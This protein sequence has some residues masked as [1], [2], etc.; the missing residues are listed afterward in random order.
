MMLKKLKRMVTLIIIIGV[1]LLLV[2]NYGTFK[3][4]IVGKIFKKKGAEIQREIPFAP[5]AEIIPV[6]VFKAKITAFKDTLP[7]LGNIK[8]FRE[9]TLKFEE[10]GVVE[11]FNFEEGERVE[12]GD[13][14]A[15]LNQRD[16]LLKL[17]Y[18]KIEV[19][20]NEKLF[21]VG[22]IVE[23]ELEKSRLEYE[24]AKS[25]FE[26]T[27]LY[28]PRDGLLGRKHA[29]EGE[30]VSPNDDVATFVDIG[31]VYAEFGIIEKDMPK[32]ALT[33]KVEVLVDAYPGTS[34]EGVVDQIAPV[35]E[36]KSRTQTLRVKLDNPGGKLKPGMFARGIIATYEKQDALIVPTSA[37]KKKEPGF[38]VYMVHQLEA[39]AVEEEGE[40]GEVEIREVAIAYMAPD[41][42]EIAEGVKEDELVAIEVREELKDKQKVEI[43]E[44]QEAPF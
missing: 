2:K 10:V 31:S 29:E 7:V 33:Q 22:A 40:F 17:E 24:S 16:A 21:E 11:S 14:V 37:V 41:Y 4:R 18:S 32:V 27:N 44:I 3:E 28:A 15:S 25:D 30:Y 5:E 8:G 6:K 19:D 1:A 39:G 43:S 9:V 36:G 20:K 34:Y 26:K 35:V 13:I 12:E 23:A 42:A 38:Y